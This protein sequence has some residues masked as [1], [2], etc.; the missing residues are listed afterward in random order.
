[1][2]EWYLVIGLLGL[3]SIMGM[4]WEPLLW[5]LP[6]FLFSVV[7]VLL[8]A[9]KS[10]IH[11]GSK[12][13]PASFFARFRCLTLVTVLHL[14][15]PLARLYGRIKHG[16]TPWRRANGRMAKL[17]SLWSG[18][19]LTHWSEKW[20]AAEDWLEDIEAYFTGSKVRSRRGGHFD[21]WDLQVSPALFSSARGVLVV[22]EHGAGKQFLKFRIWPHYSLFGLFSIFLLTGLATWAAWDKAYPA[23]IFSGVLGLLLLGKYLSDTAAAITVIKDAFGSL[24]HPRAAVTEQIPQESLTQEQQT[25][26]DHSFKVSRK[27]MPF[28]L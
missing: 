21:H 20:R 7:V 27:V 24:A 18:R 16:L 22:E 13:R 8:Q 10:A 6:V 19:L 1:M 9:L 28:L 11:S 17:S 2:P 3:L 5:A 12:N 14:A 23:A 4:S 15:Q 26:L 25:V